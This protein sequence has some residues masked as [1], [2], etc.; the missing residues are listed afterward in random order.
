MSSE[1]KYLHLTDVVKRMQPAAF[2]TMVKPVGS[3]CNFDCSYCYYSDKT[4][5]Y[6]RHE[7]QMNDELLE[8]Y[9]KQYIEAVEVPAVSFCWHGGEP[10]LAG[11]DFYR[12]AMRWQ[13]KYKGEKSIENTLQT[14][15]ALIDQ[16]WCDF[17]REHNFLIGISLDG[18]ADVHDAFRRDRGGRPTF[19]RVMKAIELMARNDVEYN[20]LST[21]NV[22]CEGRGKEIYR[23]MRSL[24]H[25][26]Q[27]LPVVEHTYKPEGATRPYIVSPEHPHSKPAPWS[28]SA[29]GYGEFMC[30]IFDEWVVSDVGRYFVQLFDVSLGQWCGVPPSLCAFGETCGTG[31]AVEH[32]GDV[33]MCDHYVYPEYCLGNI[34]EKSLSEM[35]QSQEL[36]DFGTDKRDT[37]PLECKRCGYL[38]ACRGECPKHRFETTKRG[39]AGLNSLCAGYKKFFVHVDPYMRRMRML[40]EKNRPP[41][42]VMPW[43]RERLW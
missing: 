30:D 42:E 5:I 14:N 16:T 33:Y 43:A 4:E 22:R 39:E 9:I 26:M 37:L 10:L 17:F 23:F 21:V 34:R 7:P 31:L 24:S 15:G 25:Y 32:N 29:E 6:G 3:A 11:I 28:V 2:C 18:P 38:F 13:E 20:I 35:Q 1:K 19:E 27:F 12:K 40:L 8:L 36:F 41:A